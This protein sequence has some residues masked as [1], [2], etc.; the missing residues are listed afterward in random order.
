MKLSSD[1]VKKVGLLAKLNLSETEQTIYT[2]QLSDI[3]DYIDQ[4]NQIDTE[5]VEPLFNIFQNTTVLAKDEIKASLSTQD[6]LINSANNK[7][8]LFVTKGVFNDE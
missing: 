4:L 5:N 6:A 7:N 2:K 1:Q 8:D 3:F